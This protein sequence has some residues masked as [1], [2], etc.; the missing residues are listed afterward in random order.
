MAETPDVN[1]VE[2]LRKFFMDDES[3]VRQNQLLDQ[4]LRQVWNDRGKADRTALADLLLLQP[5]NICEP[6]QFTLRKMDR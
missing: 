5:S 3:E 1:P 4:I 2:E 6:I